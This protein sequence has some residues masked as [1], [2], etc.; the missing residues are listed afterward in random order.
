MRSG[1]IRERVEHWN[2]SVF[3]PVVHYTR[4]KPLQWSECSI[5][6]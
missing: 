1:C 3:V 5:F 4:L 2:S 6:L